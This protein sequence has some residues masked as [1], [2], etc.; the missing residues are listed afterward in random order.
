M[1]FCHFRNDSSLNCIPNELNKVL[2]SVKKK[3][4]KYQQ[5]KK[6][7]KK[8]FFW[9]N[10]KRKLLHNCNQKQI[11]DTLKNTLKRQQKNHH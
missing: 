1:T 6:E 5:H 7:Q 4:L 9:V 11:Q 8:T 10:Y 2:D 3:K